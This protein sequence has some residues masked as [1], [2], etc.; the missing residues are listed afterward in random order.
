MLSKPDFITTESNKLL[1]HETQPSA[2]QTT[3]LTMSNICSWTRDPVAVTYRQLKDD[4]E[5]VPHSTQK[6]WF[7]QGITTHLSDYT[8]SATECFSKMAT[9]SSFA[10][11]I[12]GEREHN[13]CTSQ[14]KNTINVL[15]CNTQFLF[16]KYQIYIVYQEPIY[17]FMTS[18]LSW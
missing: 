3:Y 11:Q 5:T 14:K 16:V 12:A 15:L 2:T 13:Q 17:L 7:L 1:N 9:V 4:L 18:N 8:A 10:L 6:N